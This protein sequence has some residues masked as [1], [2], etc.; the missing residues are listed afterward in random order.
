VWNFLFERSMDLT[1]ELPRDEFCICLVGEIAQFEIPPIATSKPALKKFID[2]TIQNHGI[3]IRRRFGF[4]DSSLPNDEQ[5]IG[6]FG[7]GDWQSTNEAAFI[8]QQKSA[9]GKAKKPSTKLYRNEADISLAALAF[10]NVV[11]TCDKKPGPLKTAYEQGGKVV[12]LQDFD[13]S[14]LS[15]RDYVKSKL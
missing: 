5:R 8:E 13:E 7:Y 2:A 10:E 14:G 3:K 4:H 1:I 11:L 15:L 6:G 9:L 12:F